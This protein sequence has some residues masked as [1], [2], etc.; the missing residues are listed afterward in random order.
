MLNLEV[1]NNSYTK[2][3]LYVLKRY[4]NIL[5]KYKNVKTSF[6][7]PK[8]RSVSNK[9]EKKKKKEVKAMLNL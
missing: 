3:C 7:Y 6:R 2:H 8:I 9:Q 1:V 5:P 4:Q